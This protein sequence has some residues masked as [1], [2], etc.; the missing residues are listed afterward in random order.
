MTYEDLLKWVLR[1]LFL[2]FL[3]WGLI[4][5]LVR[6]RRRDQPAIARFCSHCG[7]PTVAMA[8]FCT[9]CSA[10]L[11]PLESTPAASS[12]LML[13]GRRRARFSRKAM[14]S[15]AFVFL[16]PVLFIF[17]MAATG[18][19]PGAVHISSI[20]IFLGLLGAASFVLGLIA[21]RD[22]N[23]SGGMLRGT[24]LAVVGMLIGI[25]FA[26]V[27]GINVFSSDTVSERSRKARRNTDE[28]QESINK[29]LDSLHGGNAGKDARDK[30]GTR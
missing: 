16:G 6:R 9:R 29:W 7:A 8:V 21:T 4:R 5:Y 10:R 26:S 12:P 25:M 20:A 13:T 23:G 17:A 22:I 28:Q 2:L 11:Q 1:I 24:G 30:K 3:S 15:L 27:G 14:L 18:V 19:S